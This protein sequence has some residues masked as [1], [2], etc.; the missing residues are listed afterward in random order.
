ML[1]VAR[2]GVSL[3]R[4]TRRRVGLGISGLLRVSVISIVG[5]IARSRIGGG[6]PIR[7]GVVRRCDD[8]RGN[9]GTKQAQAKR[10]ASVSISAAIVAATAVV[11]RTAVRVAAAI[12]AP[13][14]PEV[15]ASASRAY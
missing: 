4:I 5:C 12:R 7:L 9:C 13:T 14:A 15:A 1:R 11:P 10:D 3:L 8:R 2:L 6:I